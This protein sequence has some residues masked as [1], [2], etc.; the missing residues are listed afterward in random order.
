MCMQNTV[1]GQSTVG[2][3]GCLEAERA[4]WDGRLNAA[5]QQVMA[6]E[7]AEDAEMS[8]IGASVPNKANALKDMQRAWISYRDTRCRYIGSQW[9]GGS[10]TGP[11]IVGCHMNLTGQQALFLQSMLNN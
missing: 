2:I 7:K 1:G 11:A 3:G 6:N 4:Q 8:E 9:G 10:G 5:Y